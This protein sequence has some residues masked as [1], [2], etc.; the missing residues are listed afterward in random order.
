M[1]TQHNVRN[2]ESRLP[3]GEPASLLVTWQNPETRRYFLMGVL[4]KHS[5]EDYTFQYFKGVDK[6]DEFRMIPGFPDLHRHYR[7]DV[8]FPVFSSRLM[9]LR[10]D[11]RGEWLQS[12]GLPDDASDIHI[13]GRTFGRRLTDHFELLAVPEVDLARRTI[14]G[15]TPL[16]GLRHQTEGLQLVRSGG[17]NIGD[18]LQIRHEIDNVVHDEARAVLTAGGVQLGYLPWPLVEYIRMLGALKGDPS[19]RVA[20]INPS[21]PEFHQQ[22]LLAY[23]WRF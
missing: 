17:L 6:S 7:S 9:S 10:R 5:A 4:E 11:D 18:S 3:T 22:I 19:V 8:L 13:L 23:E 12:M 14:T 20:H 21:L 16:H 1:L 15:T 2:V